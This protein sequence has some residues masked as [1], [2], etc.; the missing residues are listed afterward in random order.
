MNFE[1]DLAL[2]LLGLTV[3]KSNPLLSL[4]LSPKMSVY[5]EPEE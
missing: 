1:I 4:R 3:Q 2:V 5:I